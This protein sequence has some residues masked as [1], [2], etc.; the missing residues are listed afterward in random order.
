[1]AFFNDFKE[2]FQN[3]A[4]T[5]TNKTK[6]GM[7]TARLASES[8]SVAND[9]AAVYEQI[10]RVYV[11]SEGRNAEELTLLA[12][13][14]VALKERMEGLERQRMQLRNQ[15]RCPAC[16]AAAAKDARFCSS[17]GRRMPESAPEAEKAPAVE[18]VNYCPECGA[19]LREGEKFCAV[20]GFGGEEM[21]EEKREEIR[22]SIPVYTRPAAGESADEAPEDFEAD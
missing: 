6:D 11:E 9:L 18:D 19:M 22:I 5:V 17:C 1:M 21:A 7:E 2:L 4:Q 12:A 3:A 15:S 10:G 16:G 14:A 13:K 20:C 8:R